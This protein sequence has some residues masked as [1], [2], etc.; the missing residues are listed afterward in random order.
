MSRPAF[1]LKKVVATALVLSL[2]A[3]C[4]SAPPRIPFTAAD[5]QAATVNGMP[6]DIRF[7]ATTSL[8]NLRPVLTPIRERTRRTGRGPKLLALSGGA[9]DG[10]YGAGFLN[11]WTER[12]DRPEFTIV[13]GISTGA[14]IA[15]F[16]FLGPRYDD[17]LR[18]VFTEVSAA[19][20]FNFVGLRGVLGAGLADTAPLRAMIAK[21]VTPAFL[22]EVAAEHATGRRLFVVSTNLDAQ[23]SVVWN[24]G[25]IAEIGGPR[26]LEMFREALLASA[27]IPAVFP[28]VLVDVEAGGIPFQ[29]LH[30][31]GG[32]TLQVFT[33]PNA[34]LV[35]PAANRAPPGTEIYMIINNRLFPNFEVVPAR[36]VRVAARSLDTIVKSSAFQTVSETYAFA[37][38]RGIDFYL[39]YIAPDFE[40]DYEGPFNQDYMRAL[41]AYGFARGRSGD[42]WRSTLP[43]DD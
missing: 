40:R 26:A 15:P 23:R 19:N 7:W 36:A 37:V 24:M 6:S 16:A 1:F 29:E 8:E 39:T 34:I 10:A 12:G 11:G 21:H 25:R 27:S 9:D 31:D 22:E 30:V 20:V 32:A 4:A 35:S 38:E 18:E 41:F 33:L 5:Q 17:A 13:S 42:G 3:A 14:L 43:F 2:L 28:P